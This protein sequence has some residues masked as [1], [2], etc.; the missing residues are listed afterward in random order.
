MSC[1]TIQ[2][3]SLDQFWRYLRSEWGRQ[4]RST[5]VQVLHWLPRDPFL[6]KWS[7]MWLHPLR[8]RSRGSQCGRSSTNEVTKLAWE[9]SQTKQSWCRV[10]ACSRPIC[11]Y[12]V[13]KKLKLCLPGS[14]S[15]TISRGVHVVCD[16]WRSL[17]SSKD[18]A[19]KTVL[20]FSM[21]PR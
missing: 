19:R 8:N 4:R 14:E 11:R 18:R 13:R 5:V 20:A 7:A 6:K 1:S 12:A 15:V 2:R 16:R 17:K 3:C 9:L 10:R 21:P